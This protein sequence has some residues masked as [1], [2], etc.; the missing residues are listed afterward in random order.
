MQDGFEPIL[1][2]DVASA[3]KVIESQIETISVC[4]FDLTLPDGSGYEL[5]SLVKENHDV[6][7]LFLTA[8]DDEGNVVKG[9][10]MGLM[11]TLLN[12]S[13]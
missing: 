9:L 3:K 13:D 5:C 12:L 7:V 1:C 10:D 4:V 11:I 6:P 8:V 2:T